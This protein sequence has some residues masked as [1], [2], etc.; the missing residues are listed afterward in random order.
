MALA[1]SL[2]VRRLSQVAV[3]LAGLLAIVFTLRPI[4]DFDVWYPLAAGRMMAATWHWPVTNTFAYTA[5]DHPWIDLHWLFQLGLYGAY[6][7]GGPNGCIALVVL[8]LLATVGTLWASARRFAPDALVALL[9]GVALVIASPRFV[10]R[11][12]LVS[13]ALLAVYLWLLDGYPRSGRAIYWLVPLQLVW[14]NS[15]GIFVIGLVV[16]GCYWAGATLAF[17][18][19]PPG[20]RKA[21][22]CSSTEWR[23]LTIVLG[24]AIVVCFLNP[25]GWQGVLFPLQLLPR[26]TGSSL[27]SGRIGEFRPPFQSGYGLPLAYTWATTIVLAALSFLV[28]IGRWHLGRFL[29][30]ATFAVLSTQALRNVA[31]FAWVAVPAIA[32]NL[33]PLFTASA[34]APTGGRGE[35]RRDAAAPPSA[36]SS[37]L[38][39]SLSVLATGGVVA[40]LALLVMSVVTNRFSHLLNIER[41]FGVGVSSLHFP[42]TAEQ[43]ARDVGIGGRPF[44]DLASGGYLAWRRFPDER[45]FVDGRLEVYPESFFRFYLDALDHPTNWPTVVERYAPDY[46][47]LYHVWSNRFPLI[48]YLRAGHGWELVYYDETASIYLPSDDAHREVRERAEREFAARRAQQ[49]PPSAPSGVW[50]AISVPVATLTRDTAYGDFLFTIGDAA[51]AVEAYKRALIIDPDVSPT[52]FSLGMAYWQSRRPNEALVEWRDIMRRDPSFDRAR[53]A[54]EEGERRLSPQ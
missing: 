16:I 29:L 31:L 41:E 47:L 28:S 14:T 52:R 18:P 2:L 19:L 32:A 46:V 1:A 20:W 43:F 9:I 39:G 42:I 48:R 10:P 37:R 27:F 22:G 23:R 44:N 51:G 33:G 45:I 54:V 40:T 11:P 26:V 53:S 8:L 3:G 36:G 38:A 6:V 12:E 5:P 35:R 17:L 25:Y 50:S 4:D 30:T 24:L 13:F 49:V 15:Q 7:L 34:R 21:S